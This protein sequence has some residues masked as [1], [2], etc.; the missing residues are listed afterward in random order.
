M[1]WAGLDKIHI[2]MTSISSPLLSFIYNSDLFFVIDSNTLDSTVF[3]SLNKEKR[4]SRW[5]PIEET[6]EKKVE[7]ISYTTYSS[8]SNTRYNRPEAASKIVIFFFL[9]LEDHC[10][11]YCYL[12]FIAIDVW[13]TGVKLP[14]FRV[15]IEKWLRKHCS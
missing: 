9:L 13:T 15:S 7:Q 4:K 10:N 5:E 1:S 8:P 6:P 12:W 3:S 14:F 2:M 11:D